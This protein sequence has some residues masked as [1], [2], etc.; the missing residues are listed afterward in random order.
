MEHDIWIGA[1]D[2]LQ[3]VGNGDDNVYVWVSGKPMQYRGWS[4][5]QPSHGGNENCAQMYGTSGLWNDLPCNW[6]L[7]YVCELLP[8]AP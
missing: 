5:G 7:P 8:A 1:H 4:P 3:P 2:N 6:L